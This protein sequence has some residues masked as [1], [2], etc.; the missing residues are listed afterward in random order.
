[1]AA[2]AKGILALFAV[3]AAVFLIAVDHLLKQRF[4]TG[5]AFAPYSTYR[6][7]PLGLRVLY[8][9][10]QDVPGIASERNLQDIN[11]IGDGADTTFFL[12]G[13][14]IWPDPEKTI[15]AIERFAETGGRF[16]VTFP[17]MIADLEEHLDEFEK[18]MKEYRE[19]IREILEEE[20]GAGEDEEGASEEEDEVDEG[21]E[22]FE[23]LFQY[24]DISERWGFEYAFR[25]L[26]RDETDDTRYVPLVAT[27]GPGAPEYLPKSLEWNSSL[28][29]DDL[30]PEWRVIYESFARALVIER[31]WGE[32]AIVLAS[33]TYY[34]SNEAMRD[35]RQTA[36]IQWFMGPNSR[37]V[38]DETHLG[39]ISQPGIMALARQYNLHGLIAAVVFITL[40]T[41]W[42]SSATLVP[43]AQDFGAAEAGSETAA[44]DARSGLANLLRRT[45]PRRDVLLTCVDEWERAMKYDGRMGKQKVSRAREIARQEH[46]R[47]RR[48]SDIAG[49]YRE[50][51]ELIAERK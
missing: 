30:D 31:D 34:L 49:A 24:V 29:F 40:L 46:A 16:V 47:S 20:E 35:D 32:G 42:H 36:L 37:M 10:L 38:F 2:N 51:S 3:V 4:D 25:G 11:R 18:E 5:D 15:E 33:D 22:R 41:V 27:P 21:A 13:A 50:I 12:C 26:T 6:S 14:S 44:R 43:R 1:M 8:S 19:R 7:D 9:S 17:S 45:V 28:Y 39:S 48:E 23:A